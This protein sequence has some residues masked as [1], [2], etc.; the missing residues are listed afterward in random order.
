VPAAI[1]TAT[2]GRRRPRHYRFPS[3][4]FFCE[5]RP[6]LFGSKNLFLF[7]VLYSGVLTF[8]PVRTIF[9]RPA[10]LRDRFLVIQSKKSIE[11][12]VPNRLPHA[13]RRR[14]VTCPTQMSEKSYSY[15]A[16]PRLCT[17][18]SNLLDSPWFMKECGSRDS[19]PPRSWHPSCL[20]LDLQPDLCQV[21]TADR[22]RSNIG[23]NDGRTIR[24]R[25]GRRPD[26]HRRDR[27]RRDRPPSLP[28]R[29]RTRPR[30][31]AKDSQAGGASDL[32]RSR[33][34]ICLCTR[35]FIRAWSDADLVR[36]LCHG[37]E[38]Q[39]HCHFRPKSRNSSSV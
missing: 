11:S 7:Q 33:H 21:Q 31:V 2:R 28:P 14:K 16:I 18:D 38:H 17:L 22:L 32:R 30:R 8:L 25:L 15:S 19:I 34:H 26:C 39:Q 24:P 4:F 1:T 27:F 13:N 20:S 29:P 3:E 6:A 23:W 12:P 9:H 5:I 10:Q 37:S 36:D 35:R